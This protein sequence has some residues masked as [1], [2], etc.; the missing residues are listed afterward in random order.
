MIFFPT[1]WNKVGGTHSAMQEEEIHSDGTGSAGSVTKRKSMRL[2]SAKKALKKL[3]RL[4][5]SPADGSC[6]PVNSSADQLHTAGTEG[7]SKQGNAIQA[8]QAH[9]GEPE[10][11]NNG[12]Q[13]QTFTPPTSQLKTAN[14]PGTKQATAVPPTAP[15]PDSSALQNDTA[16]M[17]ALQPHQQQA[18]PRV[19]LPG[20]PVKAEQEEKEN[21][22]PNQSTED[23]LP[24]LENLT[25]RPTVKDSL[26]PEE[27]LAELMKDPVIAAQRAEHMRFMGEALDM[28]MIPR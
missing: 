22:Y 9:D 10:Q 14:D 16:A 7:T 2:S 25:I 23:D 12:S 28:V 20:A 13:A 1:F 26:T 8:C 24:Q 11:H 5:P 19:K 3:F 27:Q 4:Q 17:N 18:R 21:V 15:S 6:P